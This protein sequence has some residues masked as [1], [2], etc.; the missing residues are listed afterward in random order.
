MTEHTPTRTR[1]AR[2]PLLWG[3]LTRFALGV[4]LVVPLV[5]RYLRN[6][7]SLPELDVTN[8]LAVT[9]LFLMVAGFSLFVFTLLVHGAA[10]ATGRGSERP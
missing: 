3:P 8:Y 7:L 2:A 6:D 4:A 1:S 5:V 10:I 9:G